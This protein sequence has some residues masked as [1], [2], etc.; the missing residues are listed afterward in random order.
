MAAAPKL[1]NPPQDHG[2]LLGPYCVLGLQDQKS[3]TLSA[4]YRAS[5]ITFLLNSSLGSSL[6]NETEAM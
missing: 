5:W 6:R 4:H 3:G 2:G 1:P